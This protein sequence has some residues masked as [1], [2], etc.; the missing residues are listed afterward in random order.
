M[1]LGIFRK[2]G[3][4]VSRG[5]FTPLEVA[6]LQA[7]FN[8]QNATSRELAKSLEAS[9]EAIAR[10]L[11]RLRRVRMVDLDCDSFKRRFVLNRVF[12]TL[13]RTYESLAE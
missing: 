8:T 5:V 12:M 11:R 3:V 6:I 4:V 10:S 1:D 9:Q 7:L 2:G 13:P